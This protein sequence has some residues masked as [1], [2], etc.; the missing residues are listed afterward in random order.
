[1]AEDPE[2]EAWRTRFLSAEKEVADLWSV[3][4]SCR[5]RGYGK[6]ELLALRSF[7]KAAEELRAAVRDGGG[8]SEMESFHVHQ[9][10]I[11]G[12]EQLLAQR[13]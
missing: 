2:H 1:M 13:A 6:S 8:S 12:T 4:L 10:Q 9:C 11:A 7:E 3:V 5:L